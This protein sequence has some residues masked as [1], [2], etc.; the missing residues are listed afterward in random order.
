MRRFA[1]LCLLAAALAQAD[2]A[3]LAPITAADIARTLSERV[4]AQASGDVLESL[5]D[6]G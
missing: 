4:A 1:C 2:E 6:R 3:E 5:R